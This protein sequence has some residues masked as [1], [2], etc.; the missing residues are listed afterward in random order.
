MAGGSSSNLLDNKTDLSSRNRKYSAG[1]AAIESG[2]KT[3]KIKGKKTRQRQ[4]KEVRI[5][6]MMKKLELTNLNHP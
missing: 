5:H 1:G 6:R 4:A 2:Q 3:K